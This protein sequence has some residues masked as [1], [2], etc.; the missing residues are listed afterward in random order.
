MSVILYLQIKLIYIKISLT[1][2]LRGLSFLPGW[3]IWNKILHIIADCFI[4]CHVIAL[5]LLLNC[6][7]IEYGYHIDRCDGIIH[8][9]T[10]FVFPLTYPHLCI[11]F[12]SLPNSCHGHI[13]SLIMSDVFLLFFRC[14]RRFRERASDLVRWERECENKRQWGNCV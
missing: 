14:F 5:L 2:I 13:H 4:S 11:H 8:T 12:A 1:S 9:V 6:N 7:L 10:W 3:A